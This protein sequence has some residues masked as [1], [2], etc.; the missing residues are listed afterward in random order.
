MYKKSLS[1]VLAFLMV[2]IPTTVHAEE[3]SPTVPNLTGRV[4]DLSLGQPAPYSGVLLDP[5]AASP[6]L[7]DQKYLKLELDS[8]HLYY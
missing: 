6:M 2:A 5:V 8:Q 3:T 1:V 7:V 4:T